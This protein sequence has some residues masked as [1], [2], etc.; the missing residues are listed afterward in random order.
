M[1]SDWSQLCKNR[2]LALMPLCPR[3][4]QLEWFIDEKSIV[5]IGGEAVS[6]VV[7]AMLGSVSEVAE[8]DMDMEW[9]LT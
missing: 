2:G 3:P 9:S 4:R 1:W 7:V 6:K 8:D 5:K